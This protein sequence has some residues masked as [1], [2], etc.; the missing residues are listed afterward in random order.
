MGSHHKRHDGTKAIRRVAA[1]PKQDKKPRPQP[2]DDQAQVVLDGQ[3]AFFNLLARHF[4]SILQDSKYEEDLQLIKGHFFRREFVNVFSNKHLCEVYSARYL[5]SRALAYADLFARETIC[6]LLYPP[7]RPLRPSERL[8]K[9]GTIPQKK[10]ILAIGAGVG[11]EVCALH[12]LEQK[13]RSAACDDEDD[14]EYFDQ[15]LELDVVD[16]AEYEDFLQS[17]N[18]CMHSGVKSTT[19]RLDTQLPSTRNIAV[20]YHQKDILDW[21]VSPDFHALLSGTTLVTFMFIFNELF[22]ASKSKTMQLIAAVAKHLP[23]N[24][25]VLLV[26]SAGDLSQVKLSP[27]PKS[28]ADTAQ[29]DADNQ[30][31]ARTAEDE[32]RGLMVYKF[33]DHLPGFERVMHIDRQWFRLDSRLQYPLELENVGYFVRLYRKL[34]SPTI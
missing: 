4:E 29:S 12:L 28:P 33:W 26:E 1:K 32:T 16:F 2:K 7:V 22:A 17:L 5:P 21:S 20:K 19:D 15:H 25:H 24:A 30:S 31:V 14:D 34:S 6:E 27:D 9:N 18:T 3:Q 10:K 8:K 11:S 23:A 13:R